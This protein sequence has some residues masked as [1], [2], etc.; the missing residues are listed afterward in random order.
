MS[1]AKVINLPSEHY[2]QVQ[3]WLLGYALLVKRRVWDEIGGL[4]TNFGFG[5]FED[6]EYGI[7]M[8]ANRYLNVCCRNS[9]V[10]HYGSTTMKTKSAE[11]NASLAR[12]LKYLNKKWGLRWELYRGFYGQSPFHIINNIKASQTDAIKVLEINGGFSN[13]LNLIQYRYP[14]AEVYAIEGNEKV[15]HFASNYL[16]MTCGD[17]E[18]MNIPFAFHYFD[19]I[20]LY[21]VVEYLS[22]PQKTLEKIRPY[23]KE[24]GHLFVGADNICYISAI[25]ELVR[26]NFSNANEFS[27][28]QRKKHFY[29][30]N[31]LTNLVLKSGYGIDNWIFLYPLSDDG[32]ARDLDDKE[33]EL[34]DA[35]LKMPWAGKENVYMHNG[36]LIEAHVG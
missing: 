7:R 9:F 35:I 4:D 14:K 13:T 31:D 29:T 15:A 32:T 1:L 34:L 5:G 26:G 19:Y 2:E 6:D 21:K 23:L 17:I 12:N 27:F 3:H 16:K 18:T 24:N 30:T 20:I 8:N 10:F 33:K 22:D 11:Y 36:C 25:K 28:G